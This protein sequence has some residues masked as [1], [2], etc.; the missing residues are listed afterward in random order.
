MKEGSNVFV[1]FLLNLIS[2]MVTIT[3]M[4]PGQCPFNDPSSA[5]TE[6]LAESGSCQFGCVLDVNCPTQ[7]KCC[8]QG[9]SSQCVPAENTGIF[10][11]E[12]IAMNSFETPTVIL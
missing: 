10:L 4:H 12:I 6:L 2:V 3:G 11:A 7:Q 8:M 9:C 1:D 5:I